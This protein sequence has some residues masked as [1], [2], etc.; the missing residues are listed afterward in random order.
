MM[1]LTTFRSVPPFAAGYVRDLRVRWALEEAGL[2]YTLR[3][4][5]FEEAATPA[6]RKEQPF[7]QIP[8]LQDDGL[9]LFESGAILLHLGER[10]PAL[11]PAD[12]EAR[13]QVTVWMFAALNSVE[14][15]FAELVSLAL[16][17]ADEAWAA[18][19]RPSAEAM[20][21]KRLRDLDDWLEGRDWLAGEFS[22]ADILM[23][24]V[25]RLL[26]GMELVERFDRLAAY[27]ARCM[28]RPAFDKA[29]G[30]QLALYRQLP[31]VA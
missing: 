21:L 10:C 13:A 4:L 11:L 14:P 5:A 30:D 6:Y 18:A 15:Y 8:V 24:T 25:L 31:A 19:A 17:H 1:T 23:C 28:A 29:L 2:P 3:L 12:A 16:F 27:R 7:S 22:V 26:D 20:A 9:T